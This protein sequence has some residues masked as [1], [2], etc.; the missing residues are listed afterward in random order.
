MSSHL[1]H[2]LAVVG[3]DTGVG[4]TVVASALAAAFRQKHFRVAVFKPAESGCTPGP[5]GLI[6]ADTQL[7]INASGC[8][9]DRDLVNP[10]RFEP[11]L[12]PAAAAQLAGQ[13][14]SMERIDQCYRT[15][16]ATH[17]ILIMEGAGGLLVPYGPDWLLADLLARLTIPVLVVG[18]S[19][20]GTI[21]HCLLTLR[22]LNRRNMDVRGVVLNRLQPDR[23]PEE[24]G[25]PA[26]ISQFSQMEV[27]G[28]FPYLEQAAMAVSNQ[29]GASATAHINLQPLFPL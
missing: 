14:I 29:L 21:N 26:A 22:E 9:A 23:G 28:V 17:Q 12:S 11:P 7:L 6:A 18:R 13:T 5:D 27:L 3:T 10:Y 1:C 20:L 2:C 15:L 25:N 8:Q 19:S 24:D 4:K 16:R